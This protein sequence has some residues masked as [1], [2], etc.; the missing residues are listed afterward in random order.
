MSP[1]PNPERSPTSA[2]GRD[3]QDSDQAVG[4]KPKTSLDLTLRII[5]EHYRKHLNGSS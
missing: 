3:R 2:E 4:W 5:V 1:N